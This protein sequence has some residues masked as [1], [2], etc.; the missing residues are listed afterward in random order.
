MQNLLNDNASAA[1]RLRNRPG[2]AAMAAIVLALGVGAT[3][4]VFALVDRALPHAAPSVMCE[5]MMD[6]L[7]DPSS[8]M[9]SA[10][11]A[12]TE[13][14]DRVSDAYETSFEAAGDAIESLPDMASGLSQ[15]IVL[16][17]LGAG[18]LALLVAC[19]RAASRLMDSPRASL[20]VAGTT[21]GALAVATLSLR[22]L[23]LPAIGLRAVAFAGC[24]SLLAVYFARTARRKS[25]F[26]GA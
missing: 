11:P 21:L 18:A 2:F 23:A 5:T 17:L 22:L 8:A 25:A 20:L 6:Y 9:S 3:T 10:M 1:P 16:A 14:S 19:T 13:L 26:T 24:I 12:S 15:P 4:A 7:S